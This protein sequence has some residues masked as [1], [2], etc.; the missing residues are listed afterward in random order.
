MKIPLNRVVAFAGPYIS[1]LAGAIAAWVLAKW[2]VL[3]IPGLGLN[4]DS[5][6][7]EITAGLT[8]ALTAGLSHL[9]QMKW[10]K[11]AH[12]ELA[13]DGLVQAAAL[14]EKS[15]RD[16]EVEA[17]AASAAAEEQRLLAEDIAGGA[18]PDEEELTS[19]PPGPGNTPVQPSQ[20]GPGAVREGDEFPPAR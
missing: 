16:P 3:A 15:Q 2:N 6:A 18:V 4:G 19:P 5:L 20:D 9:G 12:I 11:G 17:A 10:L 14:S 13:N 7:T 1:I 8:L